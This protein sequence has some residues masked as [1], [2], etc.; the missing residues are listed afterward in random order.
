MAAMQDQGIRVLIE[1]DDNY[2]VPAPQVPG[3]KSEWLVKDPRTKDDPHS[4]ENH[5]NIA[6]WVDGIICSTPKL[7]EIYSKVNKNVYIC[8]NSIDTQDWPDPEKPDDGIFRIGFAGSK[9]HWHDYAL[10]ERALAWAADLPDVEILI[11]G[12]REKGPA[13]KR[14]I[15]WTDDLPAYRKSLGQMDVGVCPLKP[16]YWTDCKSDVK[17]MEYAMAGALPIISK[18]EAYRPWWDKPCLVAETEKDFRR[19]IKWCVQNQDE[20][21]KLAAE[22]QA[23]VLAERRIEQ[24]VKAWEE[25]VRG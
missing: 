15:E 3:V 9:S 25:A 22:A 7:A 13:K 8:P 16:S 18:T 19:H 14:W 1:V 17:A 21:K 23:Y 6:K 11:Y 24:S 12:I 10:V 5:R 20:V 4:I 2:F